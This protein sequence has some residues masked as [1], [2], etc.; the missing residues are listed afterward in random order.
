MKNGS[1]EKLLSV[2]NLTVGYR[3]AGG[4]FTR[5][6]QFRAVSDVSFD[7]DS[8]QTLGLVGESGCGKS[9]L[10]KAIVGLSPVTSGQV[11]WRDIN[12]SLADPLTRKK[13]RAEMQM[14]FQN[15][16]SAL[17]PRMR[18]TDSLAEPLQTHFPRLANAER[19]QR[20][21]ETLELVGLDP[22]MGQRFPHE[23]SGG[24]AQ[25]INIARAI[26]SRPRLLICDEAVSALDVSVQC[27]ILKLLKELQSDLG[28]AMLFISHDLAVVRMMAHKILVMYLGRECESAERDIF[29]SQPQHPYSRVL[30][31]SVLS[32]DPLIERNR[33]HP[34]IST[35]LPSTINPPTGCVFRSR[36]PMVKPVCA[37]QVPAVRPIG[38][39][40]QVSCHQV[41][42]PPDFQRPR[43][44]NQ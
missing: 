22:A 33:I 18:I 23:F 19:R 8:S 11:F 40:Q 32:V 9:S 1:T 31:N 30:I 44:K 2:Q 24:Q 13:I 12:L 37:N 35:E 3:Q 14:V 41:I 16:L 6:R 27:L 15:P 39:K 17:N 26:I 43:E 5:R 29:F 28:L 21:G 25:R 42:A 4:P 7:L 38:P 20:I 34:G 10:A 36:C